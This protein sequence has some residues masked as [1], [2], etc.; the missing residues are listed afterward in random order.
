MTADGA[1]PILYHSKTSVCS[2]KARLVLEHIGVEWKSI[3]VDLAKGE[4]FTD[5]YRAINPSATVPTLVQADGNTLTDSNEIMLALSNAYANALVPTGGQSAEADCMRW[6]ERSSQVH[7]S[8]H[9]ITTLA[10]NR[11]KLAAL[12]PE[13]LDAKLERIPNKARAARMRDIALN[14]AEADVVRTAIEDLLQTFQAMEK[15]LAE[16]VFLVGDELTL[17]DFAMV[18]MF[19]RIAYMGLVPDWYG[20]EF[21][22]VQ[23]WISALSELP[24]YEA[25]ISM[26]HSDEVIA[27]YKEAGSKVRPQLAQIRI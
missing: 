11:E 25:A 1:L 15:A 20:D 18:P 27:K 2:Q 12:S 5:E 4:Q 17:A 23:N 22:R 13:Q 8:V 10:M 19:N 9:V 7:A 14:G 21:E 6:L 26:F 24:A 16:S 3:V